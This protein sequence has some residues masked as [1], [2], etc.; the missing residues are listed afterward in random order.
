MKNLYEILLNCGFV[1]DLRK[2]WS[3]IEIRHLIESLD[4]DLNISKGQIVSYFLPNSLEF[5]IL[6]FL[7]AKKNAVSNPLNP[8]YTKPEMEFY[9]SDVKSDIVVAPKSFGRLLELDQVCCSLKIPLYILSLENGIFSVQLYNSL[10][11]KNGRTIAIDMELET[12]LFLHTSGTTGRPKLVPLSHNSILTTCSNITNTYDLS[13]SDVSFLVMPLFH[14]HGLIGVLLSSLYSGGNVIIPGK[15]SATGFW[16]DFVNFGATW[17]SAVPTIHQIL[18]NHSFDGNIGKLRFIRSCSSSLAP[19]TLKK[20]QQ[21][22]KVAVIEAY[23]MT[24][25]SHQISSNLKN[26]VN[27]GSVG[28]GRGVQVKI[29]SIED[30]SPLEFG[31]VGQVCIMGENVISGYFNNPKADLESFF[32]DLNGKKWFKTGDLGLIDSK[33]YLWLKGRIKEIINRGGEKISPIEIDSKL[34]EHPNVVEAVSFGV[35]NEI[36][37]QEIEAAVVLNNSKITQDDL[38]NFLVDKIAKF[39]IPK[40]IHI[41]KSLPKTATGKIQRRFVAQFFIEQKSKL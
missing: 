17:Y 20:L 25:A 10:Y 36:Y 24:E 15:F 11:A 37:E 41:S 9:L 33:G 7:I 18:L 19:A 8:V 13:G 5:V 28:K 40:R 27:P 34:L 6:F 23:A 4:Q 14:V 29:F 32:N 30:D 3:G 38:I 2:Q 35:P 22:F 31:S 21:K 26:D 16:K 12:A 1:S 39:K